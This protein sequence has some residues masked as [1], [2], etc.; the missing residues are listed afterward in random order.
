MDFF[1][2]SNKLVAPTSSCTTTQD[3][4]SVMHYRW[5]FERTLMSKVKEKICDILLYFALHV[6]HY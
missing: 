1:L 2:L 6:N 4:A 5:D 3:C